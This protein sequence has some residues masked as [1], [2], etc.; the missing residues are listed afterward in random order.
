[1]PY[2]KR[3]AAGRITAVF[4]R[5]RRDSKE[6]VRAN[7]PELLKFLG[8]APTQSAGHGGAAYSVAATAVA[9]PPPEPPPMPQPIAEAPPVP[10]TP[11]MTAAVSEPPPRTEPPAEPP[12]Q[13]APSPATD[14]QAAPDQQAA[15]PQPTADAPGDSDGSTQTQL[16]AS[17]MEMARI[18]EDLIDV[19]IG[20][21]VINFTDFPNMAQSKLIN[22]RALR[23][24]MSALTNLVADDDNIL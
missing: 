11:P 9:T 8:L 1:M 10:E 7:D 15:A 14:Q 22:R 19:L 3:S 2:V 12:P 5:P 4:D 6:R 16:D 23:S 24:N 17:D 20:K 21:N 18:T 13:P